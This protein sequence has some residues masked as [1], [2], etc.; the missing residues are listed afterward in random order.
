MFFFFGVEF[1]SVVTTSVTVSVQCTSSANLLGSFNLRRLPLIAP[2]SI[3]KT[4]HGPETPHRFSRPLFLSL[5]FPP[6][7]YHHYHQHLFISNVIYCDK[8]DTLLQVHL[9]P[10]HPL[11]KPHLLSPLSERKKS[12][13][14][15]SIIVFRLFFLG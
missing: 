6:Q 14:N 8:N 15:F 11:N 1:L 5:S 4:A 2:P 12:I 3:F 9:H 13:S 7:L 10:Y